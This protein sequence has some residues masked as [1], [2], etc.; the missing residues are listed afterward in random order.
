M[1]E[2]FRIGLLGHG[3]VGAAFAQLV[4]ERADAIVPVTGLR[5]EVTGILTRSQGSFDEVLRTPT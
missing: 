2:T 3:T 5:P 4:A 1:S